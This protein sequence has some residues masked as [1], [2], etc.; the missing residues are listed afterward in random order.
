MDTVVGQRCYA[1]PAMANVKG[2]KLSSKLS[3]VQQRF[4]PG[5]VERVLQVMSASDRAELSN[6]IDLRWYPFELYDRLLHAITNTNAAGD[7]AILDQ[8]GAHSADHQLS[9]IYSAY[10]RDELVRMFK[11]MVPM[12]SHMNDPG[13]MEV[14]TAG[15]ATCTITVT[16]PKSTAAACRVSR[17]FYRRVAEIAG[18]KSVRVVEPACTSR[19]DAACRFEIYV[20]RQRA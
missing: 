8:M 12:H 2:S 11:N 10:K 15:D 5:A 6:I 7:E 14:S 20:D 4:G 19:G 18:A 16:E 13:R 1:R 17:A 3:F 9:N